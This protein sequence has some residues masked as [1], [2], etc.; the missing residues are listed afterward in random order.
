MLEGFTES[1]FQFEGVA[2]PVHRRGTGPGVLVMHEMPGITPQVLAFA[3]RLADAG[4]TVAMPVLFG[5]PGRPMSLGYDLQEIGRACVRKEFHV[6]A[7]RHA[8]PITDWLR[9]LCRDLHAE[10]GGPGVGALGM[11]FTGNLA[12]TLYVDPWV[13]APVL[14]QPSLPFA[15]TPGLRRGMHVSDADLAVVQ[16]RVKDEGGK[17]LGLR[18][19]ADPMCPGPRFR[20]LKEALGDGFEAIEIDSSR[21]NPHGL[22]PMAHSV[23]SFDFVD[24]D[25]HPTKAAFL[26]V[27]EFFRERL[28]PA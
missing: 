14:S 5:E 27:V 7:S 3:T 25:G 10:I 24:Q 15:L 4:F 20:A 19:T 2:R 21:G 18:F 8:S 23:L 6:L 22:G 28:S 17:V 9:A 1:E 11:C 12:L 26:R 16:R 13:M